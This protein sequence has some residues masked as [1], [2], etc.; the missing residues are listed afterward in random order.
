MQIAQQFQDDLDSVFS[1]WDTA[2]YTP[3]IYPHTSANTITLQ[4]LFRF[5]FTQMFGVM[6][7]RPTFLV[8]SGLVLNPSQNDRLTLTNVILDQALNS[9]EYIVREYERNGDDTTL[10][11]MTA[12]DPSQT[13]NTHPN[14]GQFNGP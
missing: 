8:R 10:L 6:T 4:G 13:A 14:R 2:T 5:D 11:I 12:Y 7:N 3:M 1:D 9:L